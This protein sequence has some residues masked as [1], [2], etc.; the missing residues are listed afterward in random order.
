MKALSLLQKVLAEA[1]VQYGTCASP[2][3]SQCLKHFRNNNLIQK[4][5]WLGK[6]PPRDPVLGADINWCIQI[7]EFWMLGFK[8]YR[9]DD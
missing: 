1:S 9:G 8:V 6:W 7:R 3:S 4:C 2:L 5:W